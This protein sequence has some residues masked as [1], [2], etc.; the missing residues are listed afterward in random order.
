VPEA[1]GLSDRDAGG[2]VRRSL[3]LVNFS[4]SPSL[5]LCTHLFF[6]CQL[7]KLLQNYANEIV[8]GGKEAFMAVFND[9]RDK[10]VQIMKDYCFSVTEV[11]EPNEYYATVVNLPQ[12][13]EDMSIFHNTT[14]TMSPNELYTIHK[15]I[16]SN[17]A[18]V[19]PSLSF[20]LIPEKIRK[21]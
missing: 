19:V 18:D 1:F 12:R 15:L 21:R 13:K 8:F 20:Y 16:E 5:F 7:T 14:I 4:L 6:L 2:G 9:S 17:K 10:G 3:T 11:P